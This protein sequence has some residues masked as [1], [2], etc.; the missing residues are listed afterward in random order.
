MEAEKK[1]I[2]EGNIEVGSN[3]DQRNRQILKIIQIVFHETYS[4][5]FLSSFFFS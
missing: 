4:I 3:V 1:R 5:L 2:F